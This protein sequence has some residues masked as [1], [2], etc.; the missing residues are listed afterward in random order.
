[1]LADDRPLEQRLH[2]A[3]AWGRLFLCGNPSGQHL[4]SLRPGARP[5]P[6]SGTLLPLRPTRQESDM[7]NAKSKSGN[8]DREQ[9]SSLDYQVRSWALRYGVSEDQLREAVAKT[10]PALR[11]PATKAAK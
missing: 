10:G 1:M 7:A 3:P 2:S 4:L 8:P 11:I 6:K 5:Q 9:I